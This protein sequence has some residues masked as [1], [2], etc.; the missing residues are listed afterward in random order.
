MIANDDF[1]DDWLESALQDMP[2][3][4]VRHFVQNGLCVS[5]NLD[6]K[7]HRMIPTEEMSP[8]WVICWTEWIATEEDPEE[9]AKHYCVKTEDH[10]RHISR[11]EFED[12]Y[13]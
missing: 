1:E 5:C 8:E 4:M 10:P 13:G 11:N 3:D 7:K 2:D 6:V 12:L 9:T